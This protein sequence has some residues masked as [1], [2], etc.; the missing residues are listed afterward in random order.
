MTSFQFK[1]A[2]REGAIGLS[3][4]VFIDACALIVLLKYFLGGSGLFI[5]QVGS[6]LD[7]TRAVH[8]GG[9]PCLLLYCTPHFMVFLRAHFASHVW[10]CIL[11]LAAVLFN[12]AP[13]P[14]LFRIFR[15]VR[16][17]WMLLGEQLLVGAAVGHFFATA[18]ASI[19][20][21]LMES[22]PIAWFLPVYLC[23][24]WPLW[25][26]DLSGSWAG[27]GYNKVQASMGPL[28]PEVN[29]PTLW[30]ALR[31]KEVGSYTCLWSPIVN[32]PIPPPGSVDLYEYVV[33]CMSVR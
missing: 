4:C 27:E 31:K 2:A 15:G 21:V 5:L 24:C 30:V 3:S 19:E 9:W 7:W 18:G 25:L 33:M 1:M 11:D 6:R 12:W 14:S 13:A 10:C 32:R 26:R 22:F 20:A 17:C 8:S 16:C 29:L 28:S 23:F